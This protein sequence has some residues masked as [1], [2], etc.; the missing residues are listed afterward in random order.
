MYSILLV[1][2][3]L[4]GC[5]DSSFQGNSKTKKPGSE[6]PVAEDNG[7]ATE[8]DVDDLEDFDS[9]DNADKLPGADEY[10]VNRSEELDDRND[11]A[12]RNEVDFDTFGCKFPKDVKE[13]SGLGLTSFAL[14]WGGTKKPPPVGEVDLKNLEVGDCEW[15]DGRD[16]FM[17]VYDDGEQSYAEP[18]GA[19]MGLFDIFGSDGNDKTGGQPCRRAA[20]SMTTTINNRGIKGSV[21]CSTLPRKS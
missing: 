17:L 3:G 16:E 5:A 21:Q 8:N 9:G 6:E 20:Q 13:A 15:F 11:L 10:D 1:S 7:P 18:F 12:N 14:G 19:G 2:V 4:I